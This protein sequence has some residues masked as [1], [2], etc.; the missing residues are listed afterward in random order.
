MPERFI[1]QFFKKTSA[2]AE[3]RASLPAIYPRLWR[4]S[5]AL[6]GKKQAAEDLAQTTV[7]RALE[8]SSKYQPGTHIDRWLFVMARR[9]WLNE[10]RKTKV[11]NAGGLVP[12]E[13]TDIPATAPS[14]ETNIFAREVM[15]GSQP[16]PKFF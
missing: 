7:L 10:V 8:Q 1:R 12:L 3:I 15:R 14:S 9:I 2:E 4:F 13:E 11:R 6:T 5:L 16:L